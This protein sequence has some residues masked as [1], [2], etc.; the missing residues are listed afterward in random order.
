MQKEA[1]RLRSVPKAQRAPAI[2]VVTGDVGAVVV[3][4]NGALKG[5]KSM[6]HDQKVSEARQRS[7]CRAHQCKSAAEHERLNKT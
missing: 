1:A 5:T 2:D 6:R 7:A 4:L 3:V